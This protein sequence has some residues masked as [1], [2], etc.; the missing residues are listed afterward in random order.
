MTEPN[1]ADTADAR[2]ASMSRVV[3]QETLLASMATAQ[4][5]SEPATEQVEP[6]QQTEG[7]KPK[8]KTPQERI[9]ELANKRREAEAKAEAAERK[10][11][12]LEARLAALET[13][14]NTPVEASTKPAREAFSSDEDFIE[15]LADWKAEQAV[16]KREQQQREA[17]LKAEA[18]AIDSAF[19]ARVKKAS[20][21]IEDFE[22]VVGAATVNVPD[23]IVMALK[24]SEHGPLLTY[25]LAKHQDEARRI[26]AMRP[27]QALKQLMQI[28]RDLAEGDST[29]PAVS[30]PKTKPRAPDPIN[31]VRGTTTPNPGP[32]KDFAEYRAR[33]K[34]EQRG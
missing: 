30:Q 1:K 16:I 26:A 13:A 19:I 4:A 15:A 20:T 11:Q 14:R 10:N 3:T 2:Q 22:E 32:A 7:E 23:F 29:P 5:A 31:P 28:E 6:E 18:E 17:Q 9:Q 25:Y 27:V 12:E 34:A 24:E 21:E 33:R 8:G